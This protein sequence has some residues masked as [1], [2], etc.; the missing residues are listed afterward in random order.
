M[1]QKPLRPCDTPGCPGRAETGRCARCR[2][3][4]RNNPRLRA[5][6]AAERGYDAAWRARRLDYLLTHPVCRLCGRLAQIP[7][8]YPVSR[9]RLVALGVADPDADEHLRPLCRPCHACETGRRQPGGWW[10]QTM[11]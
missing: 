9:R 6:N 3:G 7:D 5:L 4:R 1:P 10:L 2:D 11:P 8:H